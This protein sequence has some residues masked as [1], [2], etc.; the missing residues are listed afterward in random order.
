[1]YTTEGSLGGIESSSVELGWAVY[2]FPLPLWLVGSPSLGS[3]GR[4][5]EKEG[6]LFRKS[7]P[8]GEKPNLFPPRAVS[9]KEATW[10]YLT[11]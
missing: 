2:S 8:P 7:Q 5:G 11:V 9:V 10:L 6:G 1:M 3:Q 4:Q